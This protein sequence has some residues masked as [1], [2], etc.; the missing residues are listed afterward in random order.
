MELVR[1]EKPPSAERGHYRLGCDLYALG[2]FYWL[3][4]RLRRLP[5]GGNRLIYLLFSLLN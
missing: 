3:L 1:D 5:N 4:F 2:D